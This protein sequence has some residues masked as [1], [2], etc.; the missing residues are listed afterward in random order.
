MRKTRPGRVATTRKALRCKVPE[1]HAG[2]AQA[3]GVLS[4]HCTFHHRFHGT[5]VPR[6][7]HQ[8][9]A[10]RGCP[11]RPRDAQG[12]LGMPGN[13]LGST[14]G[15]VTCRMAPRG[16]THILDHWAW[17]ARPVH[18]TSR[19][20]ARGRRAGEPG[21]ARVD[22]VDGRED[23]SRK[24]DVSGREDVARKEERRTPAPKEEEAGVLETTGALL[25]NRFGR[26][27]GGIIGPRARHG[28]KARYTGIPS[29]SIHP[30]NFFLLSLGRV[31]RSHPLAFPSAIS[32]GVLWSTAPTIPP[33]RRPGH[34][35]PGRRS[36]GRSLPGP[37]PDR[38]AGDPEA[39]RV[40]LP[41]MGRFGASRTGRGAATVSPAGTPGMPEE[42]SAI[43]EAH[44]RARPR[45]SAERKAGPPAVAGR[46]R[47]PIG[48][49]CSMTCATSRAACAPCAPAAASRSTCTPGSRRASARTSPCT[50]RA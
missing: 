20:T 36:S 33:M 35:R 6:C 17:N 8:A 13:G 46:P 43:P 49:S 1:G 31:F 42:R 19:S 30:G 23:V 18:G 7:F 45:R 29:A 25:A 40:P 41:R 44:C 11:P 3:S 14:P 12:R 24:D 48:G 4:C 38:A 39:V 5:G 21:R 9:E 16:F 37:L 32:R 26:P 15:T 2:S 27:A 22:A 10:V 50:R 47:R 34:R 28:R